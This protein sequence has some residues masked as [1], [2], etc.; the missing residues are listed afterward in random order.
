MVF[1]QFPVNQHSYLS[2]LNRDFKYGLSSEIFNISMKIEVN[3]KIAFA[4]DRKPTVRDRR[5]RKPPSI[6]SIKPTSRKILI[7]R[8]NLPKRT[9]GGDN[10]QVGK[11]SSPI[12]PD[13]GNME[14]KPPEYR[15]DFVNKYIPLQD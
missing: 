5:G 8:E 9:R 15:N 13:I 14:Q 11:N 3:P 6:S 12:A 7:L 10:I 1:D 4:L 2:L